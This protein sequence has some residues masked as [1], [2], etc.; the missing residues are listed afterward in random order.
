MNTKIKPVTNKNTQ[1]RT[2]GVIP[3]LTSYVVNRDGT[4]QP[5]NKGK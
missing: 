5:I 3:R 4:I 2:L 1:K